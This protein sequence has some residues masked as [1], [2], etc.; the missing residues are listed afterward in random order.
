MSDERLEH[1]LAAE[2]AS[3]RSPH[4][5]DAE[6]VAEEYPLMDVNAQAARHD[7]AVSKE[8]ERIKAETAG[9]RY[10]Q[11]L[12]YAVTD[13]RLGRGHLMALVVMLQSAAERLAGWDELADE[14]CPSPMAKATYRGRFKSIRDHWMGVDGQ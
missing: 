9:V 5:A 2:V 1:Q 7:R 14:K 13:K 10:A 11:L 12:A 6:W 4:T 3:S 8:S